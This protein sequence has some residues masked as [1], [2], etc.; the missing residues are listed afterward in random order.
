MWRRVWGAVHSC[1]SI[2]RSFR[3]AS[4]VDKSASYLP[5]KL[6]GECVGV[7]HQGVRWG[8]LML[9]RRPK[10]S[11]IVA[12]CYSAESVTATVADS[13]PQLW[14]MPVGGEVHKQTVACIEQQLQ[15]PAQLAGGFSGSQP[16]FVFVGHPARISFRHGCMV[17]AFIQ[18][19][20]GNTVV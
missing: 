17:W 15:C 5:R 2:R 20:S 3:R 10:R 11:L 19:C 14:P 9:G 16:G 12:C 1:T 4:V 13:A 6:C 8:A 18:P 7:L